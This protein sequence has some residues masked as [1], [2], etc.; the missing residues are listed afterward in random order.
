M[1]HTPGNMERPECVA[2]PLVADTPPEQAGP[3]LRL[4]TSDVAA[5]PRWDGA[6]ETFLT[7]GRNVRHYSEQTVTAYRQDL[8]TFCRFLREQFGGAD[9]QAVTSAHVE[10]FL[11]WQPELAAA[12]KC[13]RLDCISS[14]YKYLVRH[15]LADRNPAEGVP[16]PKRACALPKWVTPADAQALRDATKGPLERA[17]FEVLAGLG[18]RRA[19]VLGLRT[20]AFDWESG[21][22][23]IMGKGRRERGLPLAPHVRQAVEAYLR[24]RSGVDSD[25]L[26]I[27]R[28]GVPMTEKVLRAMFRRWC[29][30]AGLADRGYTLHSLRHGFGTR[31][32][33]Q[34]V[35]APT[36][37]DL[38]GHASIATTSRYLHSD[39]DRKR[40]AVALLGGEGMAGD[41]AV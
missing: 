33:M 26:F 15:E 38:M 36:I 22:V 37:R 8:A 1:G 10:D 27:T 14:L 12:T 31:L 11:S 20:N 4:V 25:R 6:V 40:Q 32:A 13:R 19:E 41:G 9:P 7:Y 34:G 23:R 28:R 3:P 2:V 39:A 35:D 5:L 18:L 17:A 21:T 29:K 16:R 30:R 24:N